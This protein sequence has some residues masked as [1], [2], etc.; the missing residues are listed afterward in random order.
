M[1]RCMS[2]EGRYDCG[3]CCKQCL[4]AKV[5]FL[6][7]SQ[8]AFFSDVILFASDDENPIPIPAHKAVLANRSPV[9]RAM[10]ENEMEESLSGTIKIGDVSYDAL[11]AFVNYL[12][13]AE[14]CP[15]QQLACDLLVMAEKY[16]VQHLKD[17]CEK[18]LVA[19][20]N[21]DNAFMIYTFAHQ[22]DAKQII[23]AALALITNK[24]DKLSARKEY[25]ELKE[26]NPRLIFEI[27]EAYF[28]KQAN[29]PNKLISPSC[30]DFEE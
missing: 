2:C 22:H 26:R 21:W 13:T 8:P 30:S 6:T 11:R 23:D 24:M 27:Y 29:T 14:V 20:L 3:N 12:Y 10:L 15:D 18:F 16:Q 7:M 28:S 25:E 9:F 19:N 5:A 1:K 4:K 17:L